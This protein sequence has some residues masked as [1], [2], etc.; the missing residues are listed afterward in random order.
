MN[1]RKD[2]VKNVMMSSVGE[3]YLLNDGIQTK[4]I[5][6]NYLPLI[7]KTGKSNI[8]FNQINLGSGSSDS[9]TIPESTGDAEVINIIN[10]GKGIKP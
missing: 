10:L 6:E 7:R 9:K 2:K 8:I 1:T 3:V 4:Y 5:P